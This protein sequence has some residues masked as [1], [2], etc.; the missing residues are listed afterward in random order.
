LNVKHLVSGEENGI[1]VTIY[2]TMTL[3]VLII[4]YKK[5]NKIKSFKIA[6][7]KFQIELENEIIKKIVTLCGGDPRQSCLLL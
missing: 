7:L 6:K 5:L 3:A 1:K 2:M 4:A